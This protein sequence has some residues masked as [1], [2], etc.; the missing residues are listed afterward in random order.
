MLPAGNPAR[1]FALQ[2]A[3]AETAGRCLPRMASPQIRGS[4]DRTGIVLI[5]LA[6]GFVARMRAGTAAAGSGRPGARR[7][8]ELIAKC[9]IQ[10]AKAFE[11]RRL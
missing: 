9:R 11:A 3:S 6:A 1:P 7:R 8:L 4:V 5:G 10:S 2:R